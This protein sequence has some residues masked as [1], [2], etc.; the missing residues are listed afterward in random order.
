MYDAVQS[1]TCSSGAIFPLAA[2]SDIFCCRTLHQGAVSSMQVAE[3]SRSKDSSQ[4]KSSKRESRKKQEL[5]QLL[6]RM[7]DEIKNCLSASQDHGSQ[8]DSGSQTELLRARKMNQGTL[9]RDEYH[10]VEVRMALQ[11]VL[12]TLE[13]RPLDLGTLSKLLFQVPDLDLSRINGEDAEIKELLLTICTEVRREYGSLPYMRIF[14]RTDGRRISHPT[15]LIGSH[16]RTLFLSILEYCE[17]LVKVKRTVV[18]SQGSL[19]YVRYILEGQPLEFVKKWNL[20]GFKESIGQCFPSDL[21]EKLRV[22]GTAAPH[23]LFSITAHTQEARA[24]HIQASTC[25]DLKI[26]KPSSKSP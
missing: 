12:S 8:T 6:Y 3:I 9:V 11:P 4:G 13:E 5:A 19:Q 24:A 20:A 16:F 14:H 25:E 1:T 15:S 18:S 22:F 2:Q 23:L 21:C 7:H 17:R 10:R 26:E